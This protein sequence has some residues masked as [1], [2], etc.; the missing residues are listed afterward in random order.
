MFL[1]MLR[2]VGEQ[3]SEDMLGDIEVPTLVLAGELDPDKLLG[4]LMEVVI[5]NAGADRGWLA[6]LFEKNQLETIER[7]ALLQCLMRL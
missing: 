7:K 2:A 3:T 6:S 1:H 4:N 5:E